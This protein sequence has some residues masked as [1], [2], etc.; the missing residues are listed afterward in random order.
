MTARLPDRPRT[1]AHPKMLTNTSPFSTDCRGVLVSWP[2][3]AFSREPP[4]ASPLAAVPCST[5][6]NFLDGDLAVG[7]RAVLRKDGRA[8]EGVN[9]AWR[10][11][12][13]SVGV[14]VCVGAPRMALQSFRLY[15]SSMC[16]TVPKRGP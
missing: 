2:H 1:D 16:R 8:G 6:A 11:A 10:V 5:P 13:A 4:A 15:N 12:R 14:Y 7:E 9:T 3:L